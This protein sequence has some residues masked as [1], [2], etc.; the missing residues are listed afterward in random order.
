VTI[1]Q[2]SSGNPVATTILSGPLG[3]LGEEDI[4]AAGRTWR[5]HEFS[6]KVAMHPAF[7][8]WTSSNGLLSDLDAEHSQQD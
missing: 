5:A 1:E 6:L 8:I 2:P 3:Y 4:D 7:I